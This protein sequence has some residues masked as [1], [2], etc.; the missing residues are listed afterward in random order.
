MLEHVL[1]NHFWKYEK[2]D[3]FR[4]VL[5]PLIG[6][7]IF[8]ADGQHW[9]WQRKHVCRIFNV[10]ALREYTSNVFARQSQLV[11]DYFNKIT[12]DTRRPSGYEEATVD[13]Q[14]IFLLFTLGKE[15]P[16]FVFARAT[17]R[18]PRD[19]F[20]EIA[21][22]RSFGCLKTPER[23]VDFAAAFD[24][25]NVDLSSR[26]CTPFWRWVEWW[27]GKDRRIESDNKVICDFAYNLIEQRR[28][29]CERAAADEP[30][31]GDEDENRPKDPDTKRFRK[32][33]MQLFMEAENDLGE[34]LSDEALK[35]MLLN[36]ILA[37]RDT[38]AQALSWMFY[39]I[40]CS[41]RRERIVGRIVSESDDLFQS[42]DGARETPPTYERVK[43][44][45]YTEA[46]FFE[47]LRL[48]PSVPHNIRVC[49]EDDVL[50]GCTRVHKGEMIAWGSWAMG[51]DAAIWGPDAKE[52]RP[53]RWLQGEKFSPSKFVAFNMGPRSCLGKQFATIEVITLTLTLFQQFSFK[54]VNPDKEPAYQRALTLPMT[55]GL[56]VR[57]RRRNAESVEG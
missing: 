45:R 12:H 15:D 55:D 1:K 53:E 37:G 14:S 26:F 35:D 9:K 42:V 33:L 40:L 56:Q 20:G 21:F 13:L 24:R 54:L 41:E 47:A 17:M 38:T 32:D 29:E 16:F 46:C 51:R 36:F 25:M 49:V 19:T 50:P 3:L 22:G 31:K 44:Q 43:A 27:T 18:R 23:Q 2:G 28:R 6:G 52:F 39:L 8:G 5:H 48:Y 34:P 7:G 10:R 4:T 30:K 57:I 11:I